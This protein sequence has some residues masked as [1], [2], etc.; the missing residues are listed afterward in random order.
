MSRCQARD[1]TTPTHDVLCRGCRD[2]LLLGLCDLAFTVTER[3]ELGPG[4]LDALAHAV[5]RRKAT[6]SRV[7]TRSHPGPAAPLPFDPRASRLEQRAALVLSTWVRSLGEAFPSL[8]PDYHDLAQAC[9]WLARHPAE[10]ATFWEGG[11]MH[12]EVT[13]LVADIERAVDYPDERR[14]AGMCSAPL[15]DGGMCEE[16]LY[17]RAEQTMLRCRGCGSTHDVAARRD[18]LASA[19]AD[20]L[21]TAVECSRIAPHL[22]GRELSASTVRS[23]AA[24]GRL[25][26]R[27]PHPHDARR[28]PRYRLGD[29]VALAQTTQTRRRPGRVAIRAG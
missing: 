19:V 20:Q 6:G 5:A 9:A 24:D 11:L 2:R 28:A 23:W 25:T 16:D 13:A 27:P 17:A 4:L 26:P 8:R 22:L 21:A 10:L 7:R 18:V 29:V 1:C 3:G 15:P 14:Y 12:D